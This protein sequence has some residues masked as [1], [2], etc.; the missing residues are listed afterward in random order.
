MYRKCSH[1][2]FTLINLKQHPP[3]FAVSRGQ[4]HNKC[5]DKTSFSHLYQKKKTTRNVAPAH[6][7]F[8]PQITYCGRGGLIGSLSPSVWSWGKASDNSGVVAFVI[9]WYS[10]VKLEAGAEIRIFGPVQDH[11]QTHPSD[12]KSPS[13]QTQWAEQFAAFYEEWQTDES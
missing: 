6:F 13:D 9:V 5:T 1:S 11:H 12:L 3:S 4:C 7:L 8:M 10:R 2:I